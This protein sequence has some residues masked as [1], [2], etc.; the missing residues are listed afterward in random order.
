MVV[1]RT[2]C[3]P[4]FVSAAVRLSNVGVRGSNVD[5]THPPEYWFVDP[6]V[7]TVKM[8]ILPTHCRWSCSLV[9]LEVKSF[10][11][12]VFHSLPVVLPINPRQSL[13]QGIREI[14]NLQGFLSDCSV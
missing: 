1:L 2:R 14:V 9:G 3:W 4:Q 13:E 6:I 10:R 11:T 12:K 5:V 8:I 7:S